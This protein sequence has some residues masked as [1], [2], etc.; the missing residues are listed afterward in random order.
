ML[1]EIAK[2]PTPFDLLK[3]A[4]KDITNEYDYIFI[5]TPPNLGLVHANVLFFATNTI[6]PFQPEIYSMRSLE[7]MANTIV[8]FKSK[9]N[10]DLNF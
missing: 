4:M 6:I 7:K 10:A 5:D 3:N 8:K 2:Y 9:T 1:P